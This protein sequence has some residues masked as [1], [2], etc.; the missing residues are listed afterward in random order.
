MFRVFQTFNALFQRPRIRGAI[1]DYQNQLLSKV[2]N[3][4]K[5]LQE[6]LNN[7]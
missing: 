2:E 5:E 3:D 7:N 4:I 1:Y 6:K